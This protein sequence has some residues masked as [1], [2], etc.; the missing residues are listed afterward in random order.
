MVI[1]V[2]SGNIF[3]RELTSYILAEVGHEVYEARTV[4]ELMG[5]LRARAPDMIVLD[6][7]VERADPAATLRAV[8]LLS[9][10]PIV[11]IG[12]PARLGTLLNG[13]RR[14]AGAVAWP[15]RAD[16]ILDVVAGLSERVNGGLVKLAVGEHYARPGE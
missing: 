6:Q 9:E 4:E 12:E 14:P 11:W 2:A 3:R 8:R 16:E 10:A 1:V 5:A 13:D 7:Q 15:F